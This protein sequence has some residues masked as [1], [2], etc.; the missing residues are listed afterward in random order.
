MEFSRLFYNCVFM[1]SAVQGSQ[2]EKLKGREN[3]DSWKIS[4]TSYLVIKGLWKYTQKELPAAA[5]EAEKE[6][7]LK[8]KSEL[9]LLIDPSNYSY[10]SDKPTAKEAWDAVIA[11]FED[12]GVCRKVSLLQQLV[13]VKLVDCSGMEEYV[14]RVTQLWSKVQGVGFALG[15]DVVGSL[16]LGGLPSEFRPM[17]L[18]IENSG[19]EI[20][21]DFVKN[22]LLQEVIFESSANSESA[23]FGKNNNKGKKNSKGFKK[24]QKNIKC[25]ECGEPHLVKNC[26]RKKKSDDKVLMT[27]FTNGSSFSNWYDSDEEDCAEKALW[28]SVHVNNAFVANL[29]GDEKKCGVDALMTS[30][31]VNESFGSDW[32]IDSGATAHMTKNASLMK[33]K[34]A[35][36]KREV[37]VANN[38]IIKVE[39]VGDIE[40]SIADNSSVLIKDVQYI[41]DLCANLLS[42]SKIVQNSENE[43]VFNSSGY[44]IYNGKREI[45]ATGTLINNM[46]KLDCVPCMNEI[47]C[48]SKG[49]DNDLLLWHRRLRHASFSKMNVLMDLR[50]CAK[51][52]DKNCEVCVIHS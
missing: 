17:I 28:T 9:I 35:P 21:V 12:S 1:M 24:K 27:S 42:V 47:A 41:P 20:T 37:V 29:D 2:L 4:A 22:L 46:F 11:A 19:K 31:L 48:T 23:F 30:L 14:N 38:R 40:Q 44:K 3:F 6:N 45:L 52:F 43:V 10:V 36:V 39:C 32:Y 49:K 5:T 16:M 7:D 13:S 8:T 50:N 25:F 33:N 51:D 34:R 15:E 18:G 26:P